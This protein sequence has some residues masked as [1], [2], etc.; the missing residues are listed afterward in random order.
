MCAVW[1]R[2]RPGGGLSLCAGC[3]L[4]EFR[5]EDFQT[6][7]RAAQQL[8]VGLAEVPEAIERLQGERKQAAKQIQMQLSELARY[9][10][11]ELVRQHA[12]ENGLRVV[13]LQLTPT[14]GDS[15]AYAKLLASMLTAQA[16]KTVAIFAWRPA[17]TTA[18]ATIVLARS[19]DLDRDCG[20]ILRQVLGE[21]GGR[22]GGSK[23]MAQGS[24]A[25]DRV[26]AVS[27]ALARAARFDSIA[28]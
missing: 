8:S 18:P 11:A 22:G 1:R 19:R 20:A 4:R 16:E 13:T 25:A 27:D 12:M 2:C 17:D 23:D 9:R 3:G 6:L 26:Q 15:P 21:F 24:V 14:D 28:C 5:R 7:G 10:A